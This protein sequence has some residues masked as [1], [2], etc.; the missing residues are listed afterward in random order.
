MAI[1]QREREII[2]TATRNPFQQKDQ[3][4]ERSKR[5]RRQD[6]IQR[7]MAKLGKTQ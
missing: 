4:P 6:P 5:D 1:K 2:K 7:G 3:D